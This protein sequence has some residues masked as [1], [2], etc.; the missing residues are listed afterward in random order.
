MKLVGLAWRYSGLLGDWLQFSTMPV[1]VRRDK[2]ERDE[3]I[4]E[5]QETERRRK[6][7]PAERAAEDKELERQ[8]LKV[9]KKAKQKWQFMQKYHHKG[10]FF[11][12]CCAVCLA[13]Q[14]AVVLLTW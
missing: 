3:K 9:F 6:L 4:R 12:V 14:V 7:T 11:V 1:H 8:G 10:A 5:Q 2:E 13:F